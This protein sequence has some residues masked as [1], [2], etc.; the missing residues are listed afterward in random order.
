MDLTGEWFDKDKN[1]ILDGHKD[2]NHDPEIYVGRLRADNIGENEVNVLNKYFE[3]NHKYRNGSF[4][5][6]KKV[7]VLFAH[8]V[9]EAQQVNS[10]YNS[11]DILKKTKLCGRGFL[12]ELKKNSS[13]LCII[14]SHSSP[15]QHSF[16]SPHS[17]IDTNQIKSINKK[18]HFYIMHCCS[19]GDF[20][21]DNYMGGAYLLV[22]TKALY[23]IAVTKPSGTKYFNKYFL[24]D[25]LNSDQSVG[26]AIKNFDSLYGNDDIVNSDEVGFHILGDPTLKFGKHIKNSF[27][28]DKIKAPP[29]STKCQY[30]KGFDMRVLL[31]VAHDGDKEYLTNA[32][33]FAGTTGQSKSIEGIQILKI[34][35][36]NGYPELQ[37]SDIQIKGHFGYKGDQPWKSGNQFNGSRGKRQTL[38]KIAFKISGSKSKY[39][40]IRYAGHSGMVGDLDCKA[41]GAWL[42]ISGCGDDYALQALKVQVYPK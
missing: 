4:H 33:S 7:T 22:N 27:N 24:S 3:R 42:G 29:L 32:K 23:V 40:G 41:D 8:N 31:H 2:A 38:Q 14:G 16:P 30:E 39:F 35:V 13:E 1:N 37:P 12:N 26:M 10:V 17:K 6:P 19:V 18:F 11:N 15:D 21:H 36:P 34:K 25:F 28:G 20:T 9:Q 5:L